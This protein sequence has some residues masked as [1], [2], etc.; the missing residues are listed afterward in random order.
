MQ[1]NVK[2]HKVFDDKRAMKAIVSV[3][4]DEQFVVH[5]VRVIETEKGKFAA[6]PNEIRKDTDGRDVR[7][8][9]FH[10]LSSSARKALED[11]VLT[12]YEKTISNQAE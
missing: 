12:A 1:I 11:A 9:I 10:P 8:D 4:L 3:T 5:G 2:I 7:K 6:M